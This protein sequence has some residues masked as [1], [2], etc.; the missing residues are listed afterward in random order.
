M[1]INVPG[2]TLRKNK[3]FSQLKNKRQSIEKTSNGSF[4]TKAAWTMK[5]AGQPKSAV[6]VAE[7]PADQCCTPTRVASTASRVNEKKKWD[8]HT[9]M[10][11]CKRYHYPASMFVQEERKTYIH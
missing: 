9:W 2:K 10:V 4:S 6:S 3:D 11:G 7:R 8:S 1:G 5:K